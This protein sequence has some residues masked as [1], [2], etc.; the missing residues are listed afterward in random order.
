MIQQPNSTQSVFL[1]KVLLVPGHPV[2]L[3]V[4]WEP[5]LYMATADSTESVLPANR[6]TFI[7]DPF[8]KKLANL[9]SEF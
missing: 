9:C 8:Q 1:N 6:K 5:R 4:V 3:G 2:H 7:L